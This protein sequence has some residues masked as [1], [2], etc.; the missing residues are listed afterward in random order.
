[1]SLI[2]DALRKMEQERRSRRGG[3]QDLRPD[4][5]R[6]RPAT[7][8]KEAS[9]TPVLLAGGAVLLLCGLGAGFLFRGDGEE[10]ALQVKQELASAT[11]PMPVV[12]AAPVAVP[13]DQAPAPVAP[14]APLQ[15]AA[16][17]PAPV[18]SPTVIPQQAKPQPAPAA[19]PVPLQ[20]AAQEVPVAG[21]DIVISGIA[22]QDERR[23]RRAV[24]NGQLVGEG[25]EIAGARV[26][27][28]RETK[29]RLSRNGQLF[30]VPFSAGH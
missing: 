6:Y 10:P 27:E 13:A 20:A 23:M 11:A 8:E 25:A 29:V 1:M 22:Y 5:L 12:P 16:Y 7:P 9:R 2:L 14:A 18:Q 4:V 3:A 26:V 17:A 24:L 19:V 21:T 30:E 28:I 15:P